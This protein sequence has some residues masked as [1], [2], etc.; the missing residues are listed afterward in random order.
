MINKTI[1]G[2]I[3]TLTSMLIATLLIIVNVLS[4]KTLV[5]NTT[6]SIVNE[7]STD[8]NLKTKNIDMWFNEQESNLANIAQALIQYEE[9]DHSK[10]TKILG[11]CIKTNPDA[12]HYYMIYS[13]V[14]RAYNELDEELDVVPSERGWYI[15]AVAAQ[16]TIFTDPYIDY[17]TGGMVV[18][19]AYPFLVDDVQCVLLADISL[20]N[21][22][23]IILQD[24]DE[25]TQSM[26][27]TASGDVII[28]SNED[29]NPDGDKIT[30]ISSITESN[31]IDNTTEKFEDYDHQ[32]KFVKSG[33]IEATNWNLI[34]TKSSKI[35]QDNVIGELIFFVLFAIAG[36]ILSLVLVINTLKRSFVPIETL[37]E[38]VKNNII[39]EKN[40]DTSR[41]KNE[42]EELDYLISE[43]QNKFINTIRNT[44]EVVAEVNE[45]TVDITKKINDIGDKITNMSAF[46]EETGATIDTQTSG[47]STISN[48]CL[49]INAA[50]ETLA[51]KAQNISS[52]ASE[53]VDKVDN[54]LPEIIISKKDAVELTQKASVDIEQAIHD[55][56]VINEITKIVED[57]EDISSQTK[58]LSLNASIEA[59]RA[60]ESG[61]GFA[62]VASEI[63]KL[64]ETTTQSIGKIKELTEKVINASSNLIDQST[65]IIGFI[66]KNVLADYE[67]LESLGKSYQEDAN[68]Y[69]DV[70][71]EIGASTEELTASVQNISDQIR[72][73]SESQNEINTAVESINSDVETITYNSQHVSENADLVSN[74]V[75][76][77]KELTD[78]F[79]I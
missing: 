57:I 32:I 27:L 52:R 67:K 25:Y 5:N 4:I 76:E 12:L 56:K 58:L 22:S 17:A 28:H 79:N 77:L 8:T 40:V 37:K 78:R 47:L 13:N 41:Y 24:N 36:I 45:Q 65:N 21:L 69:S 35:V 1:K 63:K 26:L 6:D 16:D 73:L 20:D 38:F 48:N 71:S 14:D 70:S 49:D 62:V 44:K 39:G 55:A 11:E 51:D 72:S 66:N 54:L 33:N 18:S 15:D 10:A 34:M 31:L 46:L 30:N 29:F 53:I 42:V 2:K 68:Y 64:S 50:I 7:L 60:G 3:A 19:I 23:N 43:I 9:M 75:N 74:K 61:R 59:A